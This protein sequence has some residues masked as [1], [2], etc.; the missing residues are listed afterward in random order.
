MLLYYDGRRNLVNSLQLLVQAR[1]GHTWDF[2]LTP[3][4]SSIVMRFT[5]QLKEEGI[6]MKAIGNSNFI[7]YIFIY[8]VILSSLIVLN[9]YAH[10]AFVIA[11]NSYLCI[12]AI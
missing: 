7:I 6:I 9:Y 3:E 2:G 5:D 11:S 8:L 4:L 12:S 10:I 1:E